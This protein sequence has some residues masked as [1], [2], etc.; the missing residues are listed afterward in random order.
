M[1]L[2]TKPVYFSVTSFQNIQQ[3]NLFISDNSQN[4]VSCFDN[5]LLDKDDDDLNDA[6]RK[7]FSF[8]GSSFN[9]VSFSA[10]S[11]VFHNPP[12]DN[13]YSSYF[14]QFP[15]SLFAFLKTFRL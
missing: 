2:E 12:I 1:A 15:S 5:D 10:L 9:L 14:F 4:A 11:G 8:G 13:F 3:E 7:K 6:A